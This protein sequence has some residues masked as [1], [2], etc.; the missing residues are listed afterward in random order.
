MDFRT[1]F[2]WSMV[3]R[4]MAWGAFLIGALLVGVGVYVGFGSAFSTLVQ[5]PLN[6]QRAMPQ[7]NP[8]IT[9]ALAL[10]GFVVWRIGKTYALFV[11]LPRAAGRSAAEEFD[12]ERVKSELLEVLDERLSEIHAEVEQTKRSVE[13]LE[14]GA[15]ADEFAADELADDVAAGSADRTASYDES[16]AVRSS[17]GDATAAATPPASGTSN[18]DSSGTASATSDDGTSPGVA[19]GSEPTGS[20]GRRG[21]ASS[22]ADDPGARSAESGDPLE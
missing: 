17:S 10:V 22:E 2:K 6:P 18:A 13:A 1:A 20:D 19:D 5:D 12:T 4:G 9:L 15:A 11:T 14:R 3:Y 16:D 21:A 7:A 8:S